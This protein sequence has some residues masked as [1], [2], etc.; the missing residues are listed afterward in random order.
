KGHMLMMKLM[1]I[2]RHPADVARFETTYNSLLALVERMPNVTRRQVNAVI[3]SPTGASPFYRVLEVYFENQAAMAESLRSPRGQEAGGE[4]AS[5]PAG[6][7]D[8]MFAEVYEEAGG[9]TQAPTPP[10]P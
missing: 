8:V 5:L 10:T 9:Q 6:T 4:I 7:Y 3:G 2:F 1:I